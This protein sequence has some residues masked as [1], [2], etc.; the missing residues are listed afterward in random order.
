MLSSPVSIEP[1]AA[2]KNKVLYGHD[3]MFMDKFKKV[4]TAIR[5]NIFTL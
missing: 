3:D 2:Q 4:I 5:Q 1:D